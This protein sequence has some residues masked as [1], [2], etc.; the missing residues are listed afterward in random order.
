VR[1]YF[2]TKLILAIEWEEHF[3]IKPPV[4]LFLSGKGKAEIK[5][6]DNK[7]PRFFCHACHILR[8][9]YD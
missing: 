2:T 8:F 6:K 7:F 4:V 5:L 3:L 9:S 1:T